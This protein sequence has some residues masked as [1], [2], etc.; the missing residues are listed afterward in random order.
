MYGYLASKELEH[1]LALAMRMGGVPGETECSFRVA[2]A[3]KAGVSV[4]QSRA[5]TP[6]GYDLSWLV[7]S[8]PIAVSLRSPMELCHEVRTSRFRER[9]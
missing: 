6:V 1:G 2:G 4:E 9:G 7:D 5:Q 3:L 8:A